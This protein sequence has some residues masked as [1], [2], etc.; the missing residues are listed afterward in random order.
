MLR[1]N[2]TFYAVSIMRNINLRVVL[3]VIFVENWY[4][5]TDRVV[6]IVQGHVK[7]L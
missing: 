5:I 1:A 3:T 4:E 2:R 7:V 6:K